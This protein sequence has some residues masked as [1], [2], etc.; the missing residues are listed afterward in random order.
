M[1][2]KYNANIK[3]EIIRIALYVQE[4]QKQHVFD[5]SIDSSE[6]AYKLRDYAKDVIREYNKNND[7]QISNVGPWIWNKKTSGGSALTQIGDLTGFEMR[8]S[9]NKRTIKEL[10]TLRTKMVSNRP[11]ELPAKTNQIEI[12]DDIKPYNEAFDTFF[13]RWAN[14]AV[15][16]AKFI[17]K[18]PH[19]RLLFRILKPTHSP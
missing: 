14:E 16:V 9:Y 5:I 8:F 10:I 18:K 17:A 6:G 11:T 15:S 7:Y 13:D 1:G 2:A 19:N 3:Q 4:N 12:N